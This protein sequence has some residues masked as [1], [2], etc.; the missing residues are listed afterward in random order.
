M[1]NF[2]ELRVVFRHGASVTK[3]LDSHILCTA[4]AEV[5]ERRLGLMYGYNIASRNVDFSNESS[6]GVVGSRTGS[7]HE[8]Q[9]SLLHRTKNHDSRY[10]S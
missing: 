10:A 7:D 5:Y 1:T 6:A 4:D 2:T 3:F 8:C 9:D